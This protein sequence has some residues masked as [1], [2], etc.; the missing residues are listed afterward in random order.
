MG[1]VC[2]KKRGKE[3]D[4]SLHHN[5]DHFLDEYIAAAGIASQRLSVSND[6]TQVRPPHG[7]IHAPAGRLSH[8]PAS[9][10]GRR[11]RDEDWQSYLSCDRNHRY[12]KNSGKLEVAQHIANHRLGPIFLT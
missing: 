3:H 10:E 11:Y 9:R 2:M 7:K 12:L 4:G 5:L 1:A 6:S 8:D